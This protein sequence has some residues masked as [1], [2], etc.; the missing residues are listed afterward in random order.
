[1]Y[2]RFEFMGITVHALTKDDIFDVV[3][4][5]VNADANNLIIGNHNFHSLYL[6]RHNETMRRFY[7]QS[8]YTHIDGMSLVGLGRLLGYPLLRKH[9]T[10]YLDWF[11]EF[12]RKAQEHSWRVYF[13]GG[14][15]EVAEGVQQ[16][17]RAEYPGLQFRSHHGFDAFSPD[18]S[19][20]EEIKEFAPHVL[21]VG[22]GMPLQ[23]KWILQALD[24][25]KVNVLLPCGG[26]MDF[27]MGVQTPAPRWLGQIGME[28]LFRL[29]HR[30]R[31]LFGRYL[32][33]PIALIPAILGEL[34][35][36]N[37][38]VKQLRQPRPIGE[39]DNSNGQPARPAVESGAECS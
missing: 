10:A 7:S 39:R 2:P 24:K 15:S 37:R 20:Y 38:N 21:L 14:T 6:F 29:V 26:I 27:R 16:S 8:R 17:L 22:M 1:M 3:D 30:P 13:L 5:S 12:L 23:E 34:R 19:V 32:L 9:R 25:L 35:P 28:W 18:T 31:Q 4:A 11:E 33:E 36:R